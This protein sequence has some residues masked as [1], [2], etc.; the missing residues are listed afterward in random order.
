MYIFMYL[1]SQFKSL[2]RL[3]IM[4]VSPTIQLLRNYPIITIYLFIYIYIYFFLYIYTY[5]MKL[6]NLPAT[7]Q[8]LRNLQTNEIGQLNIYLP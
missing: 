5:F 1:S 6:D 2:L 3:G 7:S 4:Q 8:T